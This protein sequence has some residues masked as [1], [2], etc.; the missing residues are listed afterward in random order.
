MDGGWMN[1]T[2]TRVK[3]VLSYCRESN[4]E[5]FVLSVLLRTTAG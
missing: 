1:R 3:E 5:V 4:K 2:V